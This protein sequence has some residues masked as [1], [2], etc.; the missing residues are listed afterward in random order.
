MRLFGENTGMALQIKDDLF[1]YTQNSFIGKP[2]A[3]DLREQKMT[4]PLIYTLNTVDS[5]S[6]KRIINIVKNHNKDEKINDV[7]NLVKQHKGLDYAK[8]KMHLYH[9]E[10]LSILNDFKNNDANKSLKLLLD[11]VVNRKK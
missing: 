5:A 9:K 11:Y 4:L 8:E 7:V 6:K 2:V 3:A 10:A 1:D